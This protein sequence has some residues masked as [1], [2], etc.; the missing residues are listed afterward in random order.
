MG[1]DDRILKD[2]IYNA[3]MRG[4]LGDFIA[5]SSCECLVNDKDGDDN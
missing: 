3:G 1:T 5:T 4:C 2:K